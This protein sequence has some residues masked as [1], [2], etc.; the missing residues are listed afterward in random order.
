MQTPVTGGTESS[1]LIVHGA[2]ITEAALKKSKNIPLVHLNGKPYNFLMQVQKNKT[3]TWIDVARP[4]EGDLAS[5]KKTFGLRMVTS[6]EIRTPSARARVE[7]NDNY[8]FFIY[9]L[10]LYDTK[11]EASVRG[12]IDFIA[13]KDT[14]ATIHYESL[15]NILGNFEI[16][17]CKTSL[18]LLVRLVERLIIFEE[19]Q[20]RH[21]REKVEK[22]GHDVFK[23]QDR[24]VLERIMSLKRDI[25]E[26]RLSV[27]LQEPI[28]HSLLQKGTQFW[29]KNAE[30]YLNELLAE[31]TK[32][33]NQIQDYR[34]TIADFEE[35]NNQLMNIKT[36]ETI[37]RL[38][39]LSLIAFPAMMFEELFMMNVRNIP[40]AGM[41][42]SFWIVT[43]IMVVLTGSLYLFFKKRGLL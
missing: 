30:V 33:I 15:E 20:L 37:K 31:Q 16:G 40:L 17:E 10:P 12:E 29:G 41:P 39:S 35:T 25:S 4:T 24:G 21:I 1:L 7:V 32:V 22:I 43:A 36:N 11:D 13:N 9:Y 34:E 3:L 42:Y 8:I 28:L 14:V 26:Y 18:E 6:E 19:R 27:R 5:L 23:S 2:I 38:T